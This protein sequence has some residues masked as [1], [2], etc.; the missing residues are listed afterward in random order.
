MKLQRT[1]VVQVMILRVRK[2]VSASV[3]RIGRVMANKRCAASG[4]PV[5]MLAEVVLRLVP[6]LGAASSRTVAARLLAGWNLVPSACRRQPRHCFSAYTTRSIG[7][8]ARSR[9]VGAT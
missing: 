1:Q 2:D 5:G 3:L 7:V 8:D 4:D 6:G 9:L